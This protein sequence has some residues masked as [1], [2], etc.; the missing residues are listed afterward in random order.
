MIIIDEQMS[1][2]LEWNAYA[3]TSFADWAALYREN[4]P[5]PATRTHF[6]FFLD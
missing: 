1:I 6:P 4:D 5:H 3:N 2:T